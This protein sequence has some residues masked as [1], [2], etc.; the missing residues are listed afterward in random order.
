MAKK[1][2]DLPLT[3]QGRVFVTEFL[4]NGK[5]ASAAYRAAF[6]HLNFKNALDCTQQ[7][8]KFRNAPAIKAALQIAQSREM[9]KVGKVLD[10]YAITQ[11][12]VAEE[13]AK[14]AFAK[15]N[16]YV[17]WG[18][19][20]VTIKESSELSPEAMAALQE[21]SET[22]NEKTGTVVKVKP[23]DKMAALST[24]AKT[25]GM[26]TE[27]HEHEHKHVSVSFIIEKD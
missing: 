2:L 10:R 22:R 1:V 11:E 9:V 7:A 19:D 8:S 6:P 21:V 24:L 5:N 13:M 15:I 23:Y 12:R 20:G 25:L 16:D 26:M 27:K 14:I 17:E 4:K 3:D 18:P